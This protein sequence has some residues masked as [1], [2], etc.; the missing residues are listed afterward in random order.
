M[1]FPV[2]SVIKRNL[3]I[4]YLFE[5]LL[6]VDAASFLAGPGAATVLGDYGATVIKIEPHEGDG[7]RTLKGTHPIDYNWLLTSRNKKSIALDLKQAAGRK[8]LHGLAAQAD[9][10]LTNFI[11]DDMTRYEVD[12]PTIKALN[13]NVIFAHITG[14]GEQGPDIAKRAF[15]STAWWASSGLMEF[16]RATGSEPGISAP[17]M[18]DHATSMSLFSAICA[19]LYRRERTGKGC[20]V[21]TSLIANGVWSNGMALQGVLAGFNFSERRQQGIHNPFSRVYKTKDDA[22]VLLTIVNANKEWPKLAVSLGIEDLMFDPRFIDLRTLIQNRMELIEIFDK[23]FAESTL[24]DILEKLKVNEV[25][26]SHVRP[27]AQVVDDPQL[28]VN[29]VIIETELEDEEYERTIMSPIQIEGEPKKLPTKAPDVGANSREI[30]STYLN[31]T[32]QDIEQLIQDEVVAVE[33][34]QPA[35]R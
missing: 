21:S 14:Y 4:Q 32:D 17:G 12:Y 11:S 6:V 1:P 29:D 30:L 24:E 35:N 23:R 16:V 27:M 2:F 28:A 3:T 15:D 13:E 19:A 34:K 25:T 31:L 7:Y 26:H 33:R 8:V 10:F 9:I 5:D 18:G 20:Y 22:Y